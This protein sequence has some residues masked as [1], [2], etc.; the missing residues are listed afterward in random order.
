M[1]DPASVRESRCAGAECPL[2]GAGLGRAAARAANS[3]N[4]V[5]GPTPALV[6]L[7][8]NCK[9]SEHWLWRLLLQRPVPSRR[10]D[11]HSIWIVH[12]PARTSSHDRTGRAAGPA[13][14]HRP[15]APTEPRSRPFA[16]TLSSLDPTRSWLAPR[17]SNRWALIPAPAVRPSNLERLEI[18]ERPQLSIMTQERPEHKKEAISSG[19][20]SPV[21]PSGIRPRG[22]SSGAP[23]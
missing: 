10:S 4:R 22:H 11:S 3:R 5:F 16:G 6:P 8:A 19:L 17:R 13:R 18:A 15:I 21:H 9:G 12:H 20:I 2:G 1:P 14:S 23:A 7:F